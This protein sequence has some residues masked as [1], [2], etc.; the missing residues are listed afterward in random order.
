MEFLARRGGFRTLPLATRPLPRLD[1]ARALAT[2]L[3]ERPRLADTAPARRLARELAPELMR[4][5]NGSAAGNARETRP[6]LEWTGEG[7]RLRAQ[8]E[9]L[10]SAT[11]TGSEGEIPPGTRGILGMRLYLRDRVFVYTDLGVEKIVDANPIGD[12][13][14]KNSPWYL[15]TNAAHVVVRTEAVELAFGQLENRWGAGASGTLLMSDGALAVPGIFAGRTFG[16]RVRA[17]AMTGALHH[18]EGRWV[19]AHRVEVRVTDRLRIGAH[20]AA[21]YPS[22]GFDPLYLVGVIPYTIVQRLHDRSAADGSAVGNHRN[23]LLI[24]ADAVWQPGGGWQLDGELLVD[25]LATESAAQPDRLGYLAGVAWSG[26]ALGSTCDARAEFAKV[27]RYTY[28]VFY[29][30]HLIQDD[31]PLG[32]ADG[33]DVEHARFRFDR[34]FGADLRLGC[35]WNWTRKG[36]GAPGEYWDPGSGGS[37]G[38]ASHLSGVVET[39]NFPHLRARADW[40]DVVSLQAQAGVLWVS[41]LGHVPGDD[42]TSAHLRFDASVQW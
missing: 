19:S 11:V 10:A 33:P 28:A 22:S 4:L 39:R 17:V 40:R 15:S 31:V 2:L 12:S 13:I 5:G 6:P 20:E 37:R 32:Y 7:V 42:P 25:D 9:F 24:G 3:R 18:P 30:A 1:V 21:V 36:E 34:D 29:G 35:G 41:N 8:A 26:F 14:V 16:G 27:Y 23:N 38:D